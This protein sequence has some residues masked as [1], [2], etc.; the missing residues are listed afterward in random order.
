MAKD[1]FQ[2]R[3]FTVH[4][5]RCAMKVGTDGT[6][7]GAWAHGG[8]EILDIGTGTGLMALMMAQR[9]PHARVTGIDIDP[10]AISQAYDNVVASPFSNRINMFE[11]D[12]RTLDH[13]LFMF[14]SIVCNPPYFVNSLECPDKQRT[15][16]RHASTLTYGDMMAAARRLLSDDGELSIVVPFDSK[17]RLEAEAALV[18]FLKVRECSVKTTAKKRPRRFLLA[19]RKH[20]SELELTEGVI[21]TS[22]GVRSL[23]YQELTKDFYL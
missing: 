9:F 6:L 2:F 15:M 5:D 19:Y 22:P 11:A 23:W 10:E 1:Y 16:A 14:N 7:L 13:S 4:Q 21:E 18:G 12:V 17:N 8:A 20:A 3:K